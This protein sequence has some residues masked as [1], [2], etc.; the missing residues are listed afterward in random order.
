M[1]SYLDLSVNELLAK[2]GMGAHAPGSG[3]AAA[4]KGLLASELLVT[5]GRL[6]L[7][8]DKYRDHYV[9]VKEAVDRIE[10][11]LIPAL[12]SLFQEDAEA[13]DRVFK[14]RVARDKESD[15]Q[16]KIRLES[17]ALEE[18]KVAT[19]I[20]FRIADICVELVDH[21]ESLF[22][23]G[24]SSARGDTGAAFS[25]AIA[26]ALAS[27]FIIN[28]NLIPFKGS[29]WARQQQKRCDELQRTVAEK[30]QNA[31]ARVTYLRTES[32]ADHDPTALIGKIF[33]EAKESYSRSD[34]DLRVADVQ[35]LV[36]DQHKAASPENHSSIDY[37]S[38]LRPEIALRHLGYKFEENETLGTFRSGGET[39]EVAGLLEAD[40][41]RVRISAQMNQNVRRFTA[42]HELGHVILHPHLLEAHRDRP[43]DGSTTARARIELE[44]DRFASSYLMPAN[45]VRSRFELMFGRAPFLLSEDTEFALGITS[46]SRTQRSPR[47]RRGLARTL[48]SAVRYN[49]RQLVPLAAQFT[50]SIEAMAIR[51]EEL[52]LLDFRK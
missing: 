8:K 7:K 31:L 9:W 10:S 25:A 1:K 48:A 34:I 15:P 52:R 47:S 20:P 33:A 44:A 51:L 16:L 4:F 26:G 5:V 43:L 17:H 29:Y 22:D 35:R 32:L 50:V 42:A 24:F 40:L 18:L 14:S 49:G 30:H 39:F 28:L 27:V 41:G 11:H 2:F 23:S 3:S 46:S 21:A 38:L 12:R 19:A 13:F 45:L 36:W 6:T 37:V